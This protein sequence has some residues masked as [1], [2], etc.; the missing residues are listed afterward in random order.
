LGLEGHAKNMAENKRPT[1]K[2]GSN[3]V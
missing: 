2:R 3:Q 1:I